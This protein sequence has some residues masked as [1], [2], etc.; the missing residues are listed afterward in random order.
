MENNRVTA[1]L[2]DLKILYNNALSISVTE[3]NEQEYWDSMLEV[4]GQ[5]CVKYADVINQKQ[6]VLAVL[7]EIEIARKENTL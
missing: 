5:L 7:K 2:E 3:K 6:L 4:G 1:L